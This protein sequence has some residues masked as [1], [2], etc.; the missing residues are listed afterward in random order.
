MK[1][2]KELREGLEKACWKGYKPIGTKKKNGKTVPNCVP[3][4]EVRPPL[5]PSDIAKIQKA[6]AREKNNDRPGQLRRTD[7][8]TRKNYSKTAPDYFSKAFGEEVEQLDERGEDAK[9]YFR[10]TE[11]GAGIT[12]KGAKHFGI[13]TAVTTPPSKLDPKGKAAKR[14]KSFCARMSGMK[15]PMKD[16]KGRPT[17]KAMSLRRWNCE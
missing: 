1:T 10:S 9:G 5:T 17:R 3:V 7:D 2:F 16:D 13:K 11:S 8:V 4:N 15:G 12:R 6:L 14:R